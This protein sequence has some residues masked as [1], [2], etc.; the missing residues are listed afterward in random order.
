M[1]SINYYKKYIKYKNKYLEIKNQIGGIP[2]RD[3]IFQILE[4]EDPEINF[5]LN[6]IFGYVYYSNG[7]IFNYKYFYPETSI[8]KIIIIDKVFN[9]VGNVI[10]PSQYLL[11]KLTCLELGIIAGLLYLICIKKFEKYKINIYDYPI[12]KT[13]IQAD[14]S[15]PSEGSK[16]R[17][18]MISTSFYNA[19]YNASTESELLDLFRL[20]LVILWWK[21]ENKKN[22]EEYYDGLNYVFSGK[23][24]QDKLRIIPFNL[25]TETPKTIEFKELFINSQSLIELTEMGQPKHFCSN[26]VFIDSGTIINEEEYPNCGEN[27]LN[28]LFNILEYFYSENFVCKLES[29][30]AN[31]KLINYYK[32][33]TKENINKEINFYGN[34]SDFMAAWSHVVSNLNNVNYNRRGIRDCKEYKFEIKSGFSQIP[35]KL[36][37]LQVISE[38]IPDVNSWEDFTTKFN[39][40]F[41]FKITEDIDSLGYGNIIINI[42][43]L[44][45]NI[46]LIENHYEISQYKEIVEKRI[47]FQNI[48]D[49]KIKNLIYINLNINP[50][51]NFKYIKW[52]N[53]TLIELIRNNEI[54]DEIYSKIV[55]FG[56]NNFTD[57]ENINLS[58]N[59]N[60]ISDKS[61]LIKSKILNLSRFDGELHDSLSALINLKDLNL[62][63]YN[64]QL[65]GSLS[66]LTNLE[67]LN[68]YF[69]NMPLNNSLS[70]LINLKDLNLTNYNHQ[71][72]GSLSTLIN[73]NFLQLNNYNYQLNGSL[74]TLIK[75][76]DLNLTN[77]NHQLNGSL[78]T[79]INLEILYF[80]LYDEPLNNSLS[81]LIKLK[82][83]YLFEYDIELNGSLSTLKNLEILYL[84]NYNHQ[85][86]GSLSILT[87]LETL[88]LDSYNYRLNGSLSTLTNLE[89]LNLYFYNMPLNNS[90]STLINLKDLN[91]TNYNHQLNN[92]LST[93]INLNF[94]QLNNYNMPLNGSLSTLTNL[95]TLYL[96]KYTHQLNNSSSTLTNLTL[97]FNNRQNSHDLPNITITYI[98]ENQS[99][100]NYSSDDNMSVEYES[101]YES[102][103]YD[104]DIYMV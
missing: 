67:I 99:S 46:N 43:S 66:T 97:H 28:N 61:I 65:N 89:I 35:N 16:K 48:E 13:S 22:I 3:I 64:H 18:K 94:L 33:F 83:L 4:I 57:D 78:S 20:L 41:K 42:N 68:L 82:N 87:N 47:Q 44:N 30:A 100:I 11:P 9:Q 6:P 15:K 84:T 56:I 7:F 90:L 24:N 21:I 52:T 71:L 74:S 81:T 10:Q 77:Y 45:F 40:K 70:K 53:T 49:E 79:L 85:L 32:T 54:S 25:I 73:L 72:N 95:E 5:Y 8:G 58:I 91:L 69:Y 101:N 23:I 34:E 36:N 1:N 98:G 102:D 51:Q 39:D 88:Y 76:K 2:L 38:L 86:N 62:T 60:K 27:V 63:K 104:E 19:F 96:D 59:L 80:N 75:L 93:L 103:Y 14:K 12:Y 55:N 92:S 29:L 26:V 50:N 17:S 31:H 37:I